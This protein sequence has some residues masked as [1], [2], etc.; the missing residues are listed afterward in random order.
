MERRDT[1]A[2]RGWVPPTLFPQWGFPLLGKTLSG[3]PYP[4]AKVLNAG[5]EFVSH[6]PIPRTGNLHLKARLKR[7]DDNGRRAIITQEL[8]TLDAHGALLL[9][10]HVSMIVPLDGP[11]EKGPKVKK[12]PVCVPVDARPIADWRISADAG[13]SF[14]CLTG[15][16]NPIHWVKTY[17]KVAGF[18]RT[19]LH[20]FGSLA[21][22]VERIRK[23]QWAGDIHGPKGLKVRFTRPLK[24]PAK[25]KIYVH[26]DAF[27]IGSAPGGRAY[28]EGTLFDSSTSKED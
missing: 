13:L 8:L 18:G 16:F 6:Q 4:L 7:I 2:W 23:T 11:K 1:S 12:T 15:D 25:V 28:L 22:A 27:Y 5:C 19:I 21:G 9:E 24:L 20:G 3:V 10:A 14:A 26:G 17:A